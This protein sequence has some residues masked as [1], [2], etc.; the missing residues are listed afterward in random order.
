[1]DIRPPDI[2]KEIQSGSEAAFEV[3]FRENYP[4]LCRYACQFLNDADE[5]EETVQDTFYNIWEKRTSINIQGSPSS[6]LYRAVH[7]RC[8]NRLRK[9]KVRL[10]YANDY[11][12]SQTDSG[13]KQAGIETRELEIRISEAVESLPAQCQQVFRLS[14]Y[15]DLKYSEIAVELGISVKTV[16]NHMGKALRILREKLSEYLTALLIIVGLS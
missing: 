2:W 16:E 1:M 11:K 13:V 8:M 14:R 6:Y 10:E 4:G 9:D 3:L 12:A 15:H 5:S 7:N